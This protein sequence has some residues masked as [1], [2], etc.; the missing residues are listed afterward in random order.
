MCPFISN[1]NTFTRR[2][3]FSS[4]RFPT[5]A[6]WA[7]PTKAGDVVIGRSIYVN[8]VRS[9]IFRGPWETFAR[10]PDVAHGRREKRI[11]FHRVARQLTWYVG[12]YWS[13]GYVLCVPNSMRR[14]KA[15]D[16][17]GWIGNLTIRW[18][19]LDLLERAIEVQ[20]CPFGVPLWKKLCFVS[21]I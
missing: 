16:W 19:L 14:Q 4:A 3:F 1:E 7:C 12:G 21:V 2:S 10:V 17:F 8:K 13:E 6:V 11:W 5:F 15:T 18:R 9:G 20:K